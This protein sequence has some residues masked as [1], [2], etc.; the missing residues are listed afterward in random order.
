MRKRTFLSLSVLVIAGML[1]AACGPAATPEVIRETVEVPVEVTKEVT[2][3]QVVQPT[4]APEVGKTQIYWYIGLGTGSQAAQIP[5]EREFV[6]KYN[7]TKGEEDG[8]QLI[9]IIVDNKYARDNLIAQVAAGNAPDIVGPMGTEGRGWFQGAWLDLQPL[10]DKFDYDVSDIDPAFLEFYKDQG[11]LV[12]LP[13]AIFPS[14]LYYNKD[15]FD[16][17]GL[18]YPPHKVGEKYTLDGQ[19]LEWNFD[20]LAEVAKRLTV[21]ASGNDAASASFDKENIAQYGFDFQWVKDSPRWFSAYFEPFYPVSDAGQAALSDGQI[22]AIKWYYDAM[23]GDQPFLPTQAA[24]DTDYLGHSN[25]FN[26]G[27]VAMGLT[28]LWYTCCITPPSDA[29]VTVP[30]WDVAVVPSYNGKTTAKMHGD[31]FGIMKDTKHP[32]EAFKVYTYL[33]GEG[34]ADLYKIYGGLPARKSQQADFFKSLDEKFAPNKVDWQVF[35]DMISYLE[36]PSHEKPLPNIA[37]AH[38]G[39]LQLGSDLRSNPDLDI[40][41]RIE[42]FLKDET[43]IYKEAADAGN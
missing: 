38:D 15:L 42:Q 37:K 23:W 2:V 32:E 33:I 5:Q 39:F 9:T 30:N 21:D 27:H 8:I 18:A 35:I 6:D 34:A 1:F 19:E 22:A 11:E 43:A 24:M 16:E 14:A 10:V 40:D 25:S 28:H 3:T 41:A 20:T 26:S 13:F 4:A 29:N 7:S 12:G 31:T 36:V 17:A